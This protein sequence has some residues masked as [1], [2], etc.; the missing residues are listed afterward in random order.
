MLHKSRI[1]IA[2][3]CVSVTRIQAIRNLEEGSEERE[4]A[5]LELDEWESLM[6]ALAE[7]SK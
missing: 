6:M 1:A 4:Y 5:T 3:V 7:A 2:A